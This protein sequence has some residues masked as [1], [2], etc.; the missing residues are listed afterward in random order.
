L[1]QENTIPIKF[2][3]SKAVFNNIAIRN[4]LVRIPLT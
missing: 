4:H 1:E 3:N 2:D